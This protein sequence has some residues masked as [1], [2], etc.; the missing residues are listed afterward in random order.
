M[1]EHF[2]LVIF[3]AGMEDYANWAIDSLHEKIQEKFS[4]PSLKPI[5]HRLFRQHA[6]P[7]RD[8][9]IKDLSALGRDL[10]KTMIVD[11][12]PQNFLLQPDNGVAIRTWT[13][14]PSDTALAELAPLLI[15]I[16]IQRVP[17]VREALRESKQ[18][19]I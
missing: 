9:Y 18:H 1:A 15:N 3:T 12:I 16:V 2:E 8:C 13:D 7:C 4:D 17:D 5:S 6:L 19:L 10:S 14:D 11:N